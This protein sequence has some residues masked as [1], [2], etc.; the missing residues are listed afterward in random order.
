[1]QLNYSCR[2]KV[3]CKERSHEGGYYRV[4]LHGKDL[5]DWSKLGILG[6]L[7]ELQQEF[8]RGRLV[9]R[10]PSNQAITPGCNFITD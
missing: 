8:Y 3:S 1:M 7:S 10:S 4:S 2:H 9:L 5:E 6:V